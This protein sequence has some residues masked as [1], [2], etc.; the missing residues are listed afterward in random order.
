[1]KKGGT[2][3]ETR[4]GETGPMHD[5]DLGRKLP[6]G[7]VQHEILD[8]SEATKNLEVKNISPLEKAND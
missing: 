4:R 6:G 2:G 5:E 8:K 7:N 3:I 1:M